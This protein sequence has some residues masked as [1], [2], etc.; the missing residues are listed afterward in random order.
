MLTLFDDCGLFDVAGLSASPFAVRHAGSMFHIGFGVILIVDFH[1][2]QFFTLFPSSATLTGCQNPSQDPSFSLRR[3]KT[4]KPERLGEGS[5]IGKS[6]KWLG[7]GAKGFWTHGTKVSQESLAPCAIPG[8]TSAGLHRCKTG[9]QMVQEAF[10][11]LGS[12]D[13]LPSP[14]HFRDFLLLTPLPGAL[15]CKTRLSTNGL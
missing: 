4:F 12:Q 15:V 2:Q 14:D 8:C 10:R 6:R 13:L 11:S 3:H 7:E 9:L 5:K 1:P